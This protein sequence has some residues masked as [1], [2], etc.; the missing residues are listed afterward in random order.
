LKIE[1][2]KVNVISDKEKIKSSANLTKPSKVGCAEINNGITNIKLSDNLHSTY[3]Y[4][5]Y[6]GI[7]N[8]PLNKDLS[9][10]LRFA[11]VK[12]LIQNEKGENNVSTT[13]TSSSKLSSNAALER[14][15]DIAKDEQLSNDNDYAP[16]CTLT[17]QSSSFGTTPT[18]DESSKPTYEYPSYSSQSYTEPQHETHTYSTYIAPEPTSYASK[19]STLASSDSSSSYEATNVKKSDNPHSTYY[20]GSYGGHNDVPLNKDLTPNMKFGE[21]VERFGTDLTSSSSCFPPQTTYSSSISHEEYLASISNSVGGGN[22]DSRSYDN[23]NNY[24]DTYENETYDDGND[25][26]YDG[27]EPDYNDNGNDDDYDGCE[28]DYN[29]NGN[30]DDYDGC[31]PDYNADSD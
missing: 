22:Y 17:S 15:E 1:N 11:S 14:S 25:D 6:H 13:T 7:Q 8:V 20:Y 31:E 5:T 27:C 24:G 30:D 16:P 28:P 9:P 21:N 3:Y 23:S 12:R 10:N 4:G 2:A 29:D 26:Y 18:V 19:S